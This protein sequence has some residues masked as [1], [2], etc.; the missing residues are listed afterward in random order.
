M[1]HTPLPLPPRPPSI[2]VRKRHNGSRSRSPRQRSDRPTGGNTSRKTTQT[3]NDLAKHRST[4]LFIRM[5]AQTSR[6]IAGD[7]PRDGLGPET[8]G[9][10][11]KILQHRATGG[12]HPCCR[13]E[14]GGSP[15]K[16]CG[17]CSL[18]DA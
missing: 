3:V 13:P 7:G 1:R 18:G 4:D 6:W 11:S 12:H 16:R 17:V 15:T 10:S 8:G 2:F 9:V 14:I 5:G